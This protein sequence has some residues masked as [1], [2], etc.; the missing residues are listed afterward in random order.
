MEL[1]GLYVKSIVY[2]T[3]AERTKDKERLVKIENFHTLL[4]NKQIE[5]KKLQIE[6]PTYE[7]EW[8]SFHKALYVY[9]SANMILYRLSDEDLI[10]LDPSYL[11]EAVKYGFEEEWYTNPVRIKRIE[12]MWVE[13]YNKQN[14]DLETFYTSLKTNVFTDA[15]GNLLVEDI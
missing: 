9:N 12:S 10:Q 1:N 14:F 15:E 8:E 5:V 13:N 6:D 2:L 11:T 3:E 4:F 7:A